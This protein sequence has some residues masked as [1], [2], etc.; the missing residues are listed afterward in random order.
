MRFGI[1]ATHRIEY[2]LTSCTATFNRLQNPL[3]VCLDEERTSFFSWLEINCL[4]SSLERI[5]GQGAVFTKIYMRSNT[6]GN[7][8]LFDKCK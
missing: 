7:V 5:N 8:Y 2:P 1:L 3:E 4:V 6:R